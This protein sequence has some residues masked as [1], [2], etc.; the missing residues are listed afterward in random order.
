M[1]TL[2]WLLLAV[3][4][5]LVIARAR[6][7]TDLS[8][9]LPRS[10]DPAQRLL[11]EQLR[12][13]VASRLA[14]VAIRGG[15]AAERACAS[16]RLAAALA[17]D[18]AFT[19][20]SNGSDPLARADGAF[21]MSH[22]YLLSPAVD[23]QRFTTAGLTAAIEDTLGTLASP[24]GALTKELLPH[25]PTGELP[26]I[27]AAL[28]P[29]TAPTLVQGVWSTRDAGAALLLLRTRASGADL[30]GQEQAIE[31]V[32]EA[33]ARL[34]GGAAACAR[35]GTLAL[36][37]TGAPAFAVST[38]NT[39]RREVERFSIAGS[40]FAALLLLTVYRSPAALLLGLLPVAS[41]AL[42]G[43]AA[44]ALGF[45]VVHGIT[46]G[47]GVTLIG[48]AVDYSVY[49]FIQAGGVTP[50]SDPGRGPS[51]ERGVWP[52]I[53]LGMLTSLCGF[54]ALLPAGFP[55]LAQLGL[56]SAAGILAAGA[57]TRFILPAWTPAGL[58]LADLAPLGARVERLRARC[59]PYAVGLA[60][61]PLASLLVLAGHQGPLFDRELAA[62]SPV[63]A[64]AQ[65]LDGRLRSE[66]GAPEAG[67]LV[68]VS[69]GGREA[70]LEAAEALAPRLEALAD[71]GVIGG[72]DT[73]AP[74]LPSARA[75]RARRAS[76]PDADTLRARLRAALAGTPLAPESLAPFVADVAAAR[77]QPLITPE[78]LAGT[79][80]AALTQGMLVA[81]DGQWHVLVALRAPVSGRGIELARVQAA[82]GQ[83]AGP[84]AAQVTVVDV[85]AQTDALYD[86]YLAQALGMSAAGCVAIVLLLAL[87]LRKLGRTLRVIL[88]LALAVLLVTDVLLLTGARLTLL[89]VIGGLLI[90]A[91]GSN[92]AL[93]FDRGPS[94]SAPAGRMLASLLVAN[95]ATV[96]SFGILSFSRLP[97]LASLGRTVAPGTLLALLFAGLLAQRPAQAPP[98]P[99]PL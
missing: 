81:A 20:V 70:A 32:H 39:I 99:G 38:R 36:T 54:A 35:P 78:Q 69:A 72:F 49:Y 66:L 24:L 2:L 84:V 76:L 91:I 42:A 40:L 71:T 37:V 88:P 96:V 47:F 18:A 95:A 73:P 22:R 16:Q 92:Y 23:P 55:G 58:R 64:A 11:L 41:G 25:D 63:P 43:I 48:E 82:L 30:D 15:T 89:H 57:V 67:D 68:V 50:G 65:A 34:P 53:R 94:E 87:T 51:F 31:V 79:S 85:K 27:L 86:A 59:A 13:G 21:L 9:F 33:F 26:Q 52:T 97:V 61:I 56:Y 83:P 3:L 80:F 17:A 44:V 46:L 6:F 7:T 90:V 1:A 19:Q 77:T 98:S 12:S 8:G 29:R 45:G 28:Q 75:Q 5:V 93:F 4:G 14:I 10:P 74:W 62:L 60:V